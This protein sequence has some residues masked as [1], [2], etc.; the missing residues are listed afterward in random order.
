[1]GK[2]IDVNMILPPIGDTVLIRLESENNVEV[3]A[4]YFDNQLEF[5]TFNGWP[6]NVWRITHWMP[7]P[8]PDLD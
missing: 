1:M 8:Y 5:V 2:W 3:D 4:G 7:L 6:N